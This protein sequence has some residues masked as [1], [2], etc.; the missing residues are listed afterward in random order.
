METLNYVLHCEIPENI[1]AKLE[2]N[3]ITFHYDAL[4][5]FIVQFSILIIGFVCKTVNFV[6]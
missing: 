4:L 6:L 3:H 1:R 2:G 5:A